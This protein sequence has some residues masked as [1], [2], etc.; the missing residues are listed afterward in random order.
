MR[1]LAL[2]I[3]EIDNIIV[4][5]A[6]LADAR[7]CKI[8]RRRRGKAARADDQNLCGEKLFLSDFPNICQE[9][10]ARIPL[11]LFLRQQSFFQVRFLAAHFRRQQP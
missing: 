1:Y 6:D 10:L 8:H 4:D 11:A 5:D 2:Q 9:H 7:C 3:G